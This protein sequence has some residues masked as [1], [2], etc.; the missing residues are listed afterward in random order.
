MA[1]VVVCINFFSLLQVCLVAVP[2][3][4]ITHNQG[5]KS[6]DKLAPGAFVHTTDANLTSLV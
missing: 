4:K 1:A 2:F 6:W 3:L 5:Q